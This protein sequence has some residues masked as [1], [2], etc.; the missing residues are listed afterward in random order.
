MY[1]Y[2]LPVFDAR[3]YIGVRR[4]DK[5]AQL[6]GVCGRSRSQ[7]HMAHELASAL[8]QG[9]PDPAAPRS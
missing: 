8:Q 2:E 9:A 3:I 7:L 1:F 6:G 4:I 5:P